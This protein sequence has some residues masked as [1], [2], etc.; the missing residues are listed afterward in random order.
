MHY[1]QQKSVWTAKQIVLF[2][3]EM[4]I[5]EERQEFPGKNVGK[6][7]MIIGLPE[8]VAIIYLVGNFLCS[9]ILDSFCR[10]WCAEE[11]G[12]CAFCSFNRLEQQCFYNLCAHWQLE[13]L[14]CIILTIISSSWLI[15]DRQN[16]FKSTDQAVFEIAI[17]FEKI[18]H[19]LLAQK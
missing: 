19:K 1:H 16:L 3:V 6:L 12:S 7:V 8:E 17:D 14:V 13:V 4:E 15:R 11:G 10:E 2:L 18:T 9:S 5:F